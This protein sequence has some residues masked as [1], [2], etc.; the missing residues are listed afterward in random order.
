MS[1]SEV[2]KVTRYELIEQIREEEEK[3]EQTEILIDYIQELWETIDLLQQ[4]FGTERAQAI[5]NTP[6]PCAYVLDDV[7]PQI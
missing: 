1:S 7:S 3:S 6:S 2:K 4:R 5:I